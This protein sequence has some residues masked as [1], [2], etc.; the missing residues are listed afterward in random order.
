M[1]VVQILCQ[2]NVNSLQQNYAQFSYVTVKETIQGTP[3]L[4]CM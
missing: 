2:D 1:L 4:Y 3:K